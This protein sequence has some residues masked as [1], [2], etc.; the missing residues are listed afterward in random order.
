MI[1]NRIKIVAIQAPSVGSLKTLIHL[2]VKDLEPESLR[3]SNL[4]GV[5]GD[6]DLEV[7]HNLRPIR[8]TVSGGFFTIALGTAK[9]DTAKG[10]RSWSNAAA[11][12]PQS[13][14]SPC[15]I[16]KCGSLN[17]GMLGLA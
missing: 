14:C 10:P 16:K 1:A 6:L 9:S 17:Q 3:F 8:L 13:N 7:V 15:C 2:H 5:G 4:V 11:T 12:K